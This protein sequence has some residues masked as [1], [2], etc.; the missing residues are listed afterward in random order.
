VTLP[1]VTEDLAAPNV[2]RLTDLSATVQI[3]RV[4][5][6]EITQVGPSRLALVAGVD[7]FR[8]M[9]GSSLLADSRSAYTSNVVAFENTLVTT[10]LDFAI[11]SVEQQPRQPV[12]PGVF[13]SSHVGM[14]DCRL[15][16]LAGR[17]YATAT[18]RDRNSSGLC[19]VALLT[20]VDGGIER[21]IVLPSPRPFEDERDWL[22]FVRHDQL[23]FLYR[24]DPTTVLRC[25]IDSGS[26]MTVSRLNAPSLDVRGHMVGGTPGIAHGDGWLFVVREQFEVDGRLLATHRVMSLDADLAIDGMSPQFT[27]LGRDDECCTGLATDGD[28]VVASLG[29]DAGGTYV[30]RLVMED[31]IALASPAATV[32]PSIPSLSTVVRDVEE[33]ALRSLMELVAEGANVSNRSTAARLHADGPPQPPRLLTI[34]MATYDDFDGVYFTVQALRLY[35]PEVM[36]HV[37]LIVLDNNPAGP[38]ADALRALADQVPELRYVPCAEI[39]GTAVRDLLFHYAT[40][41]WVM[42]IDCHVLLAPGSLAELVAYL[43]E[44]A[45]SDDL[46]QGPLLWDGLDGTVATH[47]APQ[48]ADG[49][50]GVWA[51]DDLGVSP[52]SEPFDIPSQGLGCFVARRESWLGFNPMFSGFGGE[53]GYIHEKYRLSGRRTLCLPFLRWTHRFQRPSGVSY[54]NQWEDR[55]RNYLIGWD[56]VGL[57]GDE[58]VEHFASR[59]GAVET[60]RVVSDLR[61][62]QSNPFT[63]FGGMFCINLDRRPD[64]W[65]AFSGQA[66]RLGI[67]R[68]IRRLSAVETPENHHIGCALSHRRAIELAYVQGLESV[69]VFEDDAIFLDDALDRARLS[70]AELGSQA[71][72]VCF[73]GGHRWGTRGGPTPPWHALEVPSLLTCTHAVAYHHGVFEPLLSALPATVSEM[74]SWVVDNLA[75]DQYLLTKIADWRCFVTAPALAS[76]QT[77]LD[78]EDVTYRDRYVL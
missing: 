38:H 53:E 58:V 42:V 3:R 32:D 12:G 37:S 64:R 62:E 54:T 11:T 13:P 43:E 51:T 70:F 26:L 72:D 34:G 45:D 30:A 78:Q 50:F 10:D 14:E 75:I 17:I 74:T 6:E 1:S 23:H 25:D 40:S 68:R 55:I 2:P 9:S 77:I 73:L 29:L 8:M 59:V 44:H 20:L 61:S 27:F 56:E 66:E 48:W 69:L 4:D 60:A 46:L 19:E 67:A 71:W 31:L 28:D 22:P 63:R 21:M 5:F 41:R 33:N 52:A 65:E 7:G 39:Q 24:T 15:F 49:M 57:P 18:V 76:Q 35:H 36:E 16:E 47:F